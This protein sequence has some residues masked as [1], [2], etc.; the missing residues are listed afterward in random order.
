MTPLAHLVALP[1]RYPTRVPD[2]LGL[3]ALADNVAEG[4]VLKP[5]REPHKP[6]SRLPLLL[7]PL[8]PFVDPI[9]QRHE[10][11]IGVRVTGLRVR[12]GRRGLCCCL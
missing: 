3:P 7:R 6:P 8:S 11:R 2:Q 5:D 9:A 1:V 4:F 12:Q 10:L